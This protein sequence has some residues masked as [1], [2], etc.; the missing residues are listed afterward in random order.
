ML[1]LIK[2]TSDINYTT[3]KKIAIFI[4]TS[5]LVS[6]HTQKDTIFVN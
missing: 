4:L 1:S 2:F 6:C 5:I 3:M